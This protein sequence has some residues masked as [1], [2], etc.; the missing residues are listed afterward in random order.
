M[1]Q[2][3]ADLNDPKQRFSWAF[4]DIGSRGMPMAIPDPIREEWSEHLT[5]CGFIHVDQVAEVLSSIEYGQEILNLLPKQEIHYQPPLRGQ[6]HPLNTSGEWISVDQE[7]QQPVVPTAS[8]MTDQEKAK[9][10]AEFK[11]EGLID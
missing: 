11:E 6:D 10:I 7:I 8:L 1:L 2:H 3:E 4:R 9:M 5:K